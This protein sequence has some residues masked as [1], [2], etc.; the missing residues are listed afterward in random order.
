MSDQVEID[1]AITNLEQAFFENEEKLWSGTMQNI[2]WS[3]TDPG[4]D[5][6]GQSKMKHAAGEKNVDFMGEFKNGFDETQRSA[7]V[8]ASFHYFCAKDQLKVYNFGRSVLGYP[9]I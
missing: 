7:V 5:R 6:E 3:M 4:A 2:R 9:P 8:L 1:K